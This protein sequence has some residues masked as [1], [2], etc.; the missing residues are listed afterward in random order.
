M[1]Q[2]QIITAIRYIATAICGYFVQK[3][4]ID[5]SLATSI[6]AAAVALVPVIWGVYESSKNRRIA[7][8]AKLPEVK[9]VV[10]DPATAAAV[11]ASNVIS[12]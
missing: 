11:P 7:N 10:T 5:D 4:I 12:G 6:G 8:V 3:G 2:D 9:Q 1:T